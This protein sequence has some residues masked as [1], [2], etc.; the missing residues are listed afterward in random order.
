MTAAPISAALPP[1]ARDVDAARD[2]S[3]LP[4]GAL[5]AAGSNA[6]LLLDDPSIAWKVVG[7][8]MDIFA[9]P[10]RHGAIDGPREFLFQVGQGTVLP[11]FGYDTRGRTTLMAVGG[12]DS[13]VAPLD[14]ATLREYV[15]AHPEHGPSIVEPVVRGVAGA[16]VHATRSTRRLD[17]MA[18]DDGV[19]QIP[20]GTTLGVR[21]DVRWVQVVQRG[22]YILDADSTALGANDPPFP[23]APGAWLTADEEGGTVVVEAHDTMAVIASGRLWDSI[24]A[25][26]VFSVEWAA[27]V[28]RREEA[29]RVA[30]LRARMAA[31]HARKR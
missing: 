1:D 31:G 4:W 15:D 25:F 18:D 9:V 3:E 24:D 22:I 20:A 26:R 16:F 11:G 13:G 17:Q 21:R 19:S 23:L 30:Q 28:R 5:R 14:M 27:R 6:P 29:V 10:V 2:A 7:G 8:G 12:T